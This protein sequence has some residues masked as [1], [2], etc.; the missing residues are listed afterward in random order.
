MYHPESNQSQSNA[1]QEGQFLAACDLKKLVWYVSK[2][3]AEW[4]PELG[5]ES[6]QPTIRLNFQ[7][8]TTDQDSGDHFYNEIKANE[9][10]GCGEA[11]HYL[12]YKCDVPLA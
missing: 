10:V 12:K 9:C 7:H 11:G 6:P 2:G 8:K 3:L 4:E 1:A 5:P